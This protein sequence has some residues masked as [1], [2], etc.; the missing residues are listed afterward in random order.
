MAGGLLQLVAYGSENQYLNGNPQITFFVMVYRRYTNFSMQS[1]TVN[2]KG[3]QSLVYNQIT[4]FKTKIDRNA[5]LF[6]NMF[7]EFNIPAIYATKNKEFKWIKRLGTTLINYVRIYI[8]PTLIE[9]IPGEYLDI[10]NELTTPIDQ[11]V[12]YDEL[13]GNID[14]NYNPFNPTNTG[15]PYINNTQLTGDFLNRNYNTP[16]TIKAQRLR[17]PLP[18]WFHEHIGLSVP[19]IALQ[20]HDVYFE[21]SCRPIQ[22]LY[23]VR[24]LE[25]TV[26]LQKSVGPLSTEDVIEPT[27]PYNRYVWLPPQ[28]TSDDLQNFTR[29]NDNTW[30]FNP[31][32]EI[33]YIFLDNDERKY[34]ASATHQYLIENVRKVSESGHFGE[35]II[36]LYLFHPCKEMIIT[37]NRDDVYRRNQW[38]NYTNL[39]D[40]DMQPNNY[41]SEYYN[42]V[43]KMYPNDAFNWLGRF[44]TNNEKTKDVIIHDNL[45]QLNTNISR[46]IPEY[47]P[48]KTIYANKEEAYTTKDI[49]NFLE[50]W[51]QR[52]IN[53]IPSIDINNYLYF[54][55]P[56]IEAMQI[57]FDGNIRLDTKDYIYFS[58]M[59]PLIYHTRKPRDGILV[60]SF[61]VEP[62]K[63]QPSGTCNFSHIKEVEMKL[64]LKTPSLYEQSPYNNVTYTVNFYIVTYNI[65]QIMGG[66]GS[67]IYGN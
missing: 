64:Y 36:N 38:T 60:Y 14:S 11:R 8:G 28:D 35:S 30:N 17:I 49:E 51:N 24:K 42:L 13:I 31:T 29:L 50:N 4:T 61:S 44:R 58:N 6:S 7:L 53:S 27:T 26:I 66:M 59:Q 56:I 33:N 54:N 39:D 22:Q 43:K 20:Y 34:F 55:K 23:L 32:L 41:Q 47:L 9:E 37:A 52:P 21:V 63:F 1:I 10:F 45:Y 67:I 62:E 3:L 48:G 57:N 65:L 16:P 46:Y 25:E 5:D 19:L 15:Y 2:F 40:E 18:F 12:N